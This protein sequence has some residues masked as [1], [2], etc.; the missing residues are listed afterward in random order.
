M[1]ITMSYKPVFLLFALVLNIGLMAQHN[2]EVTI[3]GTYRPKVNKVDKILMQA[4]TPEPSFSMPG[5]ETR[6]LEIQQ[7]FP[8]KLEPLS[9][10]SLN[11]KDITAESATKNFLMAGVGTRLSPVFLYKH[12][13]MLTKTLGLGVGID[14]YSSW[15]GIKD[16]AYSG[17]MNNKFDIALSSKRFNNL[18]INGDVYYKNDVIHYY[19]V[20]TSAWGGSESALDLAAPR[21][22]YNTIGFCAALVSTSTRNRELVHDASVD[23]HYLFSAFSAAEHSADLRYGL[24]Y[25]NNWWGSK[26]HPQK[27]GMDLELLYHGFRPGT[28]V[29]AGVAA[30]AATQRQFWMEARPYL[31]MKDEFYRLHL[32]LRMDAVSTLANNSSRVT[33]HPDLQGSLFVMEKK[34]EF[35][36]GLNGGR[37][38]LTFSEVVGENPFVDGCLQLGLPNV[39]LGFDGG[40]RT[41]IMNTLDLHFGVRYRHTMNDPFYTVLS[42]VSGGYSVYNSYALVYDETRVVSVL[43]DARWLAWDKLTVDAGL[44]YN[45]YRMTLLDRPLYRP[46]FEGK[47]KVNYDFDENLTVYSSFLF[48]D[49]RYARLDPVL[50][51]TPSY[52]LKP[53]LD[54]GLGA[55][56][57]VK[58]E[59]TVFAKIDNLLHQRYQR[60]LNYP[61]TG[62]EFYAGVKMR[63]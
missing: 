11:N 17:F 24:G 4:E 8:S 10:L 3:E 28:P 20:E 44:A 58:D 63:F 55:D 54:L 36:A 1:K 13:S 49:G 34:V 35:Y 7:R 32:G 33:L 22:T 21:Q 59:L 43:A 27:L 5:T 29:T 48:Q 45:K 57:K 61:V 51:A 60:Y 62:I 19:G 15:L 46:A 53:V 42:G 23:Y 56:Y 18:Q 9:A 6:V 41:N 31:E 25:V 30:V 39:K 38:P 12:H 37:K 16:Y 40:V 14:H 52:K 47:L 2:E 26:N 50:A